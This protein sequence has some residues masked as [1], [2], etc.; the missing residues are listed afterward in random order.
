MN[1]M[2]DDDI[3]IRIYEKMNHHIIDIHISNETK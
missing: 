3:N 2:F 1:N